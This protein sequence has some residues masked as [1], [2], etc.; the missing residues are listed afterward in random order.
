MRQARRAVLLLAAVCLQAVHAAES[1]FGPGKGLAVKALSRTSGGGCRWALVIGINGYTNM[2]RLGFAR[3]DAEGLAE[4][5]V[6]SCGFLR[7]NVVLMTD[8]VDPRSPQFPTRGNLRARINQIA[9]VA[10]QNDLLF[11]SFSGHGINIEGQ[12][13]LAPIDESAHD[14]GSFVPL[15]WVKSTL[16]TCAATQRLLALDACHSGARSGDAGDSPAQALLSPLAGAAFLALASCDA[17]QL[18]HEQPELGHGVFTQAMIDGLRG[19]ADTAAEGNRDGVVTALELFQFASLRVS[20]WSLKSG[21]I[22]TPV[23]K[24]EMRGRVELVRFA[25]VPDGTSLPPPAPGVVRPF[26]ATEDPDVGTSYAETLAE[27]VA[28]DMVWVEGG[29]FPMGSDNG[30]EDARP[31]HSVNVPAFWLSR[32]E[33]TR[34]Q[35]GALMQDDTGK[36]ADPNAPVDRVSWT[37]A[38][39]FCEALAHKSG[40]TGYALPTESQWEFACRASTTDRFPF[41]GGLAALGDYA[42]YKPN[43]RMRVHEVGTLQP[44]PF[45][46]QDMLGNV[47]EWCEDKYAPYPGAEATRFMDKGLRVLRGGAY[48]SHSSL[49]SAYGRSGGEPESAERGVG[50]RVVRNP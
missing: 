29:T 15:P 18:S 41:D 44:N 40:R 28:I 34:G 1:A 17:D 39:R 45:G 10:K 48:F 5:L 31:A 50:F 37:E 11:V 21:K 20:Q 47:W 42:W 26:T 43:S 13:Y 6:D 49:I 2:P 22:Q 8:A 4:T 3:Q 27:G 46:L 9:T 35:W 32:T 23:M 25:T 33:V 36:A 24:G 7:D 12:G 30:D 19:D 16:E 38:R 14:T